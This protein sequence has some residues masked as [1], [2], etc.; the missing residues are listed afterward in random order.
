MEEFGG[1]QP[2]VEAEIFGK[3]ADLAAYCDIA[4]RDAEHE[5]LAAG[6]LAPAPAA[7]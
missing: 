2:F 1:R 5:R 3:E 6:G 4:R 7:F